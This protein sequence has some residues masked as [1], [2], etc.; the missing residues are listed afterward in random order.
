MVENIGINDLN[1]NVV[2]TVVNVVVNGINNANCS[3]TFVI[4]LVVTP[5]CPICRQIYVV[6]QLKTKT[7]IPT[8]NTKNSSTFQ[9]SLHHSKISVLLE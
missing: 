6:Q 5:L 1:G 9:L 2:D 3:K 4:M 8:P 7:R